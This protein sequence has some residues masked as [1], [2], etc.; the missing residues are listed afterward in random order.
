MLPERDQF[1]SLLES[2]ADGADIDWAALDAAAATS[3]ERRR[4]G[5]LRLVARVAEMHRTLVLEEEDQLAATLDADAVPADPV[6]WGH[7]SIASRL[8][9]G[10][11]GQIYRAHDPQLNR[12]VALK[13]LRRDVTLVSAVDRLLGEARTLAQV[14]HSNVVTVHG[15]DV[16]DGR[17]G[18][19]M[20]LIDGETLEGWLSAHG[21]LGAGEAAAVGIDLCRA[22]AAVHHQGLVHGDVKAQN[23][24]REKSGGRIVLMDFGAGRAQGAEAIGVAGTPMYLAPEVLAGA[25]PTRQ[26]DLYSLGILLFHLLTNKYPYVAIDIE[27]LRA[28]HADGYRTWLRDLRP[29][30]PHGLVHTIERAIDPDP[31]RRFNTAGAL[32]EALH[33]NPALMPA[34]ER[35]APVAAD[36]QSVAPRGRPRW[37]FALSAAALLAVVVALIVWSRIN[38]SSRGTVLADVRS[39]GVMPMADTTG[40]T[41]PQYFA[42]GLTEEL[43]SA[44]GHVRALAVK[45][46]SSLGSLDGR[47]DKEIA[48]GLDV[49]ALLKTSL[50]TVDA[51][52]GATAHLKVRARLLAAGTQSIVWSEDFERPRGESTALANAIANAIARAINRG[53]TTA[54]PARLASGRATNPAAETSYLAGRTYIEEYGGGKAEDA[55]EEFQRTLQIDAD[56]A[57]AHAGAARAYVNLGANGAIP[58]AEARAKALTEARASV[59][60][61]PNLVE[62]HVVLGHLYFVYDWDWAAAEREFRHSLDLNPN[63]PYAL[64]YYANFLAAQGRFQESV[65]L[66]DRA[67]H[68]NPQSAEAARNYALFLYYKRDYGAAEQALLDSARIDS[69]QPPLLVLRARFAE[70]QGDFSGALAD[71]RTALKMTK[72][73]AVQLRVAEVRRLALA[74]QRAEALTSLAALQRDADAGAVHIYAKDLAAIQLALG[75]KSRS[76]ELFEQAVAQR[77]PSVVWLGADP[78]LDGLREEPR[79]RALLNTIGLPAAEGPR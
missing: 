76:I 56:H 18:L 3:A 78:R 12:P 29:D 50:A 1:E 62:G 7:L 32:E 10:A 45:S 22:L 34:D 25:P 54:E 47:P 37:T 73:T 6:T 21:S 30:L 14:R 51:A 69:N 2:V 49:D 46:G 5:N 75:D 39:I 19:W 63:S 11:F 27:T 15:A 58:H 60:L 72:G 64:A 13:L 41:L 71:T 35:P 20:E 77:D 79:F 43:T 38:E 61:D 17:A 28:A 74:G 65:K 70:A 55:L 9:S 67:R 8:A 31:A 59:E 52:D 26:S 48:K 33:Q 36:R 40:S 66:A 44:L 23:V 57:G 68:L 42:A 53:M 16:R 24:M 4:Y